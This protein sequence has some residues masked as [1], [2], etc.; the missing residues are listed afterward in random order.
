MNRC[1]VLGRFQPFHLGHA[2]LVKAAVEHADGGEAVVAIGSAQAG[3]E[4]N[5]PW[6]AD[7]RQAMVEA[8]AKAEGLDVTVVQVEDIN[9]PPNWVDHA[10]KSHGTGT[11]VTSDGPTMELYRAAGWDV[12]EVPLS[13]RETLEGWRVRQ[14]VRMLS[15]VMDDDAT[16]EVLRT[17]VPAAVI[18]WLI[19]ND[20]MFRCST[21]ETGVH[22]G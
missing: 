20:A 1:I 3:W 15:T 11:L 7:E 2:G 13:E 12:H 5:N 18:E 17:S 4:A 21:F 10:S 16:R 8:W 19:E 6:T 22:A 14:T 9:D